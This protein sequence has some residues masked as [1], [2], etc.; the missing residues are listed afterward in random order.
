MEW[1]ILIVV[2]AVGYIWWARP[3]KDRRGGSGS[4]DDSGG[5]DLK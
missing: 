4:G 5:S 2:A 1:L 3:D